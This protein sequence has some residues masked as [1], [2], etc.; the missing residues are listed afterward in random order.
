MTL[1]P[2]AAI[3]MVLF[4]S[5][6][7][8]CPVDGWGYTMGWPQKSWAVNIHLLC[9]PNYEC[10]A[11]MGTELRQEQVEFE[12]ADKWQEQRF[13]FERCIDDKCTRTWCFGWRGFLC[14]F[15]WPEY[16]RAYLPF[17]MNRSIH[18]AQSP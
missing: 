2:L 13:H 18:P 6:A 4:L 15:H 11:V 3:A 10:A 7:T 17:V 14:I 8:M 12:V 1:P 9:P 5:L 16:Q